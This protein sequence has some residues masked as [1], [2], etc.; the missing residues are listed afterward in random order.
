M[1]GVEGE[2]GEAGEEGLREEGVAG[3][4]AGAE[5]VFVA[6]HDEEGLWVG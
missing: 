3:G 5:L 4:S 6:G 2:G 1:G